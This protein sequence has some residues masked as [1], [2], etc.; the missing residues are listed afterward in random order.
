M[1]IRINKGGEIPVHEQ[2][3]QQVIFGIATGEYPLG[4]KMPSRPQLA[5]KLLIAP[6]TVGAAYAELAE[7]RWL[8]RLRGRKYEVMYPKTALPDP[9]TEDIE[10]LMLR[11]LRA[12][13]AQGIPS[14]DLV[15]DVQK[16]AEAEPP[17]HFLIV[18]PEPGIGKV[19]KYEVQKLTGQRVES[20]S[21]QQLWDQPSLLRD[22]A[23]LVPAYLADLLDFVPTR[24]RAETTLLVYS[25]FSHYVEMVK[26]LPQ[27]SA[28]GMLSVSGPGLRT[29]T[30]VVAEA[31]GK[32]H[33]LVPFLLE[34]KERKPV[35]RK[36]EIKDLPP[37]VDIRVIGLRGGETKNA[38]LSVPPSPGWASHLPE[39]T[40]ED[41]RAM[42][43][44][45]TESITH[46][47]VQHPRKV[48]YRLLSDKSIKEIQ[49]VRLRGGEPSVPASREDG[50]T[51]LSPAGAP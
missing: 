6:N 22:A 2:I 37:D 3:R 49:N 40:E 18:E 19:L 50:R 13:R 36:L 43:V 51:R 31:I 4:Y 44:L 35:I 9:A 1:P 20:H 38:M 42:D 47:F 30:G 11:L 7:Q 34:R 28:V 45:F 48:M 32:R 17:D 24:Q 12:A 25:P 26:N 14:S 16:L 8:V 27:P 23:L 29:M 33:R 46:N 41:F 15:S 21:I 5:R 10:T 39:A